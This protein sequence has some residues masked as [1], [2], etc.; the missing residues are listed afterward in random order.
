MTSGE[1]EAAGTDE[2]LRKMFPVHDCI[3]RN[4]VHKV[5]VVLNSKQTLHVR[6]QYLLGIAYWSY[7]CN[8]FPDKC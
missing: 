3:L 4:K 2:L 7:A 8:Y 6:W 1:G 5:E